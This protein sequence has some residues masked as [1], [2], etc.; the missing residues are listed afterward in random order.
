MKKSKLFINWDCERKSGNSTY[1]VISQRKWINTCVS[2]YSF[3]HSRSP[4]KPV[5]ASFTHHR[6]S[7]SSHRGGFLQLHR[8]GRRRRQQH[9]CSPRSSHSYSCHTCSSERRRGNLL[10]ETRTLGYRDTE[11][12]QICR[13]ESYLSVRVG[14]DLWVAG[15]ERSP[16]VSQHGAPVLG[17]A[18]C[19]RQTTSTASDTGSTHTH[20]HA[21]KHLHNISLLQ[22]HFIRNLESEWFEFIN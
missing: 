1:T 8:R 20:A 22:D 19:H 18:L 6:L 16:G 21:S 5:S 7:T 2:I 12:S 3:N 17:V 14:A 13:W 11:M 9:T 15:G 10:C 4:L